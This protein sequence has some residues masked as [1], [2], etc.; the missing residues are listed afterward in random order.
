MQLRC[1]CCKKSYEINLDPPV[2]E[3]WRLG[4]IQLSSI[5]PHLTDNDI[6]MILFQICTSCWVDMKHGCLPA[7]SNEDPGV[8]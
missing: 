1:L 2:Y 4:L 3:D 5:A 8:S 6:D 7:E